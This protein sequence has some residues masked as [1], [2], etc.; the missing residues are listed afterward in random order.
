MNFFPSNK[1]LLVS[2]LLVTAWF[3][4]NFAI[5]AKTQFFQLNYDWDN[6]IE[7]AS[8]GVVEVDSVSFNYLRFFSES[9]INTSPQNTYKLITKEGVY[10]FRYDYALMKN[11]TTQIK[12][13]EWVTDIPDIYTVEGEIIEVKLSLVQ[14]EGESI[15]TIGD[16][17]LRQGE[18]KYFRRFLGEMLPLVFK[19]RFH[20]VFNYPH[21]AIDAN[22]SKTLTSQIKEIPI[23][24]NYVLFFGSNDTLMT[25]EEISE[26]AIRIIENIHKKKEPK[27][28]FVI[29][30]PRSPN[31]EYNNFTSKYNRII[32]EAIGSLEVEVINTET[33]FSK[34]IK[35]YLREDGESISKDGYYKLASEIANKIK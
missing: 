10:Y 31:I 27:R 26:N 2:L 16:Y 17:R 24:N 21:E 33:L 12:G 28:V 18:A 30:L 1:I 5:K 15:V 35:K 3:G 9:K 20:D 13:V 32:V 22:T 34:N 25:P 7:I 19:G 11:A 23:A 4:I 14:G 8:K 29:L 6:E